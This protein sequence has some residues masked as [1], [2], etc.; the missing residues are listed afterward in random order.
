MSLSENRFPLF[1]DMRQ[2]RPFGRPLLEAAMARHFDRHRAQE[3]DR[4]VTGVLHARV[5][6]LLAGFS[7]WFALAVWGFAGGGLSNYL[8][9]IVSG[10]IF[11]VVA[12]QLILSMVTRT[13]D[14]SERAVNRASLR[15]WA[16]WD[17]ETWQDRLSGAQ[18]ALHILLPIAAAAVGMTIFAI[19]FQITQRGGL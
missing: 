18:A 12:L 2:K 19:I 8:L 16:T 3:H 1:R 6:A 11:I 15:D 7:A 14:A 4:P 17:F 5:W 13:H 9:V 10:F